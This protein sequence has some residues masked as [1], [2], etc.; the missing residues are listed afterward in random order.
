LGSSSELQ[1]KEHKTDASFGEFG[2]RSWSL[3]AENSGSGSIG[4]SLGGQKATKSSSGGS[5]SPLFKPSAISSDYKSPFASFSSPIAP[6]LAPMRDP[7]GASS[8]PEMGDRENSSHTDSLGPLKSAD[9]SDDWHSRGLPG[10]SVWGDTPG[11]SLQ[12]APP[13]PTSRKMTKDQPQKGLQR[14]SGEAILTFPKNPN[15]IY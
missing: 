15:S 12:Q 4:D 7:L 14:K 8:A 10:L 11:F 6:A 5:K 2:G 13:A 9:K 1:R 3:R